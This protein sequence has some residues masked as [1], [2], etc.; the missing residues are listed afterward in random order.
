[1]EER[2]S[3]EM[4]ENNVPKRKSSIGVYLRE[5]GRTPLLSREEE[6]AAFI[7]L[8]E[9]KND[10]A[11]A[12]KIRDSIIKANLRL[13]VNIAKHYPRTPSMSLLDLI[14]EGNFALMRAISKFDYRRGNKL[15]TYAGPWIRAWIARALIDQG[16]VIRVP[17][18]QAEKIKAIYRAFGVLAQKN[19][20]KPTMEELVEKLQLPM[21]TV[22]DMLATVKE[23]ISLNA[24]AGN[25]EVSE[26]GDFVVDE[27]APAPG[28][29]AEES[30]MR[31]LVNRGL[32]GL[33]PLRDAVI[34]KMRS[35]IGYAHDYTL[36]E[37]G[38]H[39][40]IT[41]ERVRQV[42]EKMK[43]KLRRFLR[44]EKLRL[45]AKFTSNPQKT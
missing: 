13:V 29:L 16:C 20:R 14:Q 9:A 1:M 24:K 15:S 36:E 8:E 35:G 30:Q 33:K 5:I 18:G 2:E 38:K 43:K 41:R 10:F 4:E 25:D 37:I 26:V 6:V 39:F 44:R 23:P 19:G 21:E 40:G 34:L 27:T 31:E 3:E 17:V 22:V 45:K 32:D 42:E 7:K 12:T 11:L 28:F